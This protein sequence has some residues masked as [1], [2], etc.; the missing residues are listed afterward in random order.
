MKKLHLKYNPSLEEIGRSARHSQQDQTLEISQTFAEEYQQKLY[1]SK[2]QSEVLG[3]KK[4]D[5]TYLLMTTNGLQEFQVE[6]FDD[7]IIHLSQKKK[8]GCRL[9]PLQAR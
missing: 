8:T 2:D 5:K 7:E 9:F 3:I 1:I 6:S 4:D